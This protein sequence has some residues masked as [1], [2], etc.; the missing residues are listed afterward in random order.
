MWQKVHV[1]QFEV[2]ATKHSSMHR[3]QLAVTCF[4]CEINSRGRE[5]YVLL[6]TCVTHMDEGCISLL[7][8]K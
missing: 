3:S 2:S 4:T 6:K 5:K 8:R 7:R 1:L